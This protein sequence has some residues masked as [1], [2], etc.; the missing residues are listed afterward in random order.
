[1]Q[2]VANLTAGKLARQQTPGRYFMVRS[3]S[4]GAL[5]DVLL[6]LPGNNDE[7]VLGASAGFKAR[8][9]DGQRFAAVELTASADCQVTFIVTDNEVDFNFFEGANLNAVITG[10]L[11]LPVAPNRGADVAT[12]VYVS[13]VT[14]DQVPADSIING[15][16]IAV[17]DVEVQLVA[18]AVKRKAARFTNIG[19][20]A[21]ALGATGLTWAKRC[22]VINPGDTWT[23]DDAAN[24]KWVGI[25]DA[26]DSAS[27]TVQEVLTA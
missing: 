22:I 4:N 11:P 10:P 24:L 8:L 14:L 13:G 26:G 25:T 9:T 1:M 15:A 5:V 16:A 20:D 7:E 19:T 2:F 17:G 6:D 23:E 21:V 27:V 18:A 3:I 12:P